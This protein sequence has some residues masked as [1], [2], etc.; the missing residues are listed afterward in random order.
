MRLSIAQENAICE[1][2]SEILKKAHVFTLKSG[3]PYEEI[4]Y[5]VELRIRT[6]SSNL[7]DHDFQN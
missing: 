1:I 5:K 6:I 7:I 4:L 3:K 2:Y